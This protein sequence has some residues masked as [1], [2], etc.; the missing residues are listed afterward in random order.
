MTKAD[1]E[2]PE[3]SCPAKVRTIPLHPILAQAQRGYTRAYPT[4]RGVLKVLKHRCT[5]V[6]VT[7]PRFQTALQLPNRL[8]RRLTQEGYTFQKEYVA[9]GQFILFIEPTSY[10]A[11]RECPQVQYS[12]E[13]LFFD[14]FVERMQAA[15][16]YRKRRDLEAAELH[17]R[18]EE[19]RRQR[20]E[21]ERRRIE[22]Q[23]RVDR[24]NDLADCWSRAVA[25]D[26]FLDAVDAE[27]ARVGATLGLDTDLVRWLVW[28]RG[29][30]VHLNP[31][32]N[33]EIVF[34]I[35]SSNTAESM[36]R[37]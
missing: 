22:E 11:R 34:P 14:A 13:D 8:F 33:G 4:H 18:W 31:L 24:L 1:S 5:A 29:H 30:A 10:G 16:E 25:L 21:A 32:R 15:V 6:H 7:R 35:S 28:A 20:E 36:P 2:L 23:R 37:D 19:E 17:R 9:T 3:G 27:A 12:S 26:A